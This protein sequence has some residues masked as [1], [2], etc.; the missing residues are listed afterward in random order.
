M[1]GAPPPNCFINLP[2]PPYYEIWREKF[3]EFF[4]KLP[5]RLHT[6]D[7]KGHEGEDWLFPSSDDAEISD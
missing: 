4:R 1:D 7:T 6:T 5:I 3:A 2:T